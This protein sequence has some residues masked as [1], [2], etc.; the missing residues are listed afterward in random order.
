M[1]PPGMQTVSTFVLREFDQGSP[2]TGMAA[3]AVIAIAVAI[4][5]VCCA[6]RL[7]PKKP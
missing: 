2:A 5:S 7:V 6:R 1:H 4:M 3:M